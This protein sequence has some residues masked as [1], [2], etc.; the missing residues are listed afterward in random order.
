MNIFR[1]PYYIY[2]AGHYCAEHHLRIIS[3]FLN[4][5]KR[6]IYPA[7]DIPFYAIIGEGAVFAH[8]GIGVIINRYAVIGKCCHLESGVVVGG[9]RG[10]GVPVIGDYCFLG[11]DAKIIG[12]V[13]IGNDVIVGAGAVVIDDVPDGV[14]VAGVPARI[15]NQ[16]SDEL[17]GK[18]KT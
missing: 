9:A 18:L 13:T 17:K 1:N 15:I 2:K 7:S 16:V 14:V 6:L 5:I 10:K 3:G 12:G 4:V 8:H 11:A